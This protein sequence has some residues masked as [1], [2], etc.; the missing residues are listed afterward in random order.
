ML[1]EL[2][3]GEFVTVMRKRQRMNL[4]TFSEMMSL[5]PA[6]ISHME[7]GKRPAPAHETQ[8]R[9]ADV[10]NLTEA[11]REVMYDLAAKTKKRDI[12][13]TDISHYVCQDRTLLDFLRKAKKFGYTGADLL[14]LL[15]KE[16]S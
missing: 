10:L 3:F 7:N 1:S 9:I 2:K 13:P 8:K 16:H 12:L 14:Q 4:R 6:Y 11:E 5:S 15:E